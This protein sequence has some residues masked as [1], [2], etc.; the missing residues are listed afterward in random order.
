[1]AALLEREQYIERRPLM[2]G[3]IMPIIGLRGKEKLRADRT[4]SVSV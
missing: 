1:M 4:G 3:Y 2:R